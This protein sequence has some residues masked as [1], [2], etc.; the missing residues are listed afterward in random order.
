MVYGCVSMCERNCSVGVMFCLVVLVSW[1]DRLDRVGWLS[2]LV[3]S[4]SVCSVVLSLFVVG[5]GC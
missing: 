2:V 5:V 3:C 4:V 1:F